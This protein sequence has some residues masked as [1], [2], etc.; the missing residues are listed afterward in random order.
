M[1]DADDMTT[2]APSGIARQ[3][4][5]RRQPLAAGGRPGARGPGR[6]LAAAGVVVGAL[7]L[8]S[9]PRPSRSR[10]QGRGREVLDP[11]EVAAVAA[12]PTGSRWPPSTSTRSRPGR[13]AHP[14]ARRSTCPAPG[15]TRCASTS[16]SGPPSPWSS[17][18]AGWRASTPTGCSSAATRPAR[19][20]P[21]AGP[22]DGDDADALLAEAALVSGAARRPARG[23]VRRGAHRRHHLAAAAQRARPCVWGSAD[24]SDHKAEVLAVLLDQQAPA[25]YDVSVPGQP[26]IRE[27]R[28]ARGKQSPH[29]RRQS[30][31]A[32][33]AARAEKHARRAASSACAIPGT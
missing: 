4:F 20:P 1:T 8:V 6:V 2:S 31:T 12:V 13:A 10:G 29:Q 26:T 21:A 28:T 5:A 18:T 19:R 17:A 32:V 14:G 23:A 22:D 33:T 30:R 16:P 15:P 3:R 27:Y 11:R 9:S 25:V 24:D 7:W